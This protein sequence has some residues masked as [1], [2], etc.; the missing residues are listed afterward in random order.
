MLTQ[1]TTNS[2]DALVT[3]VMILV[4]NLLFGLAKH[5]C[6]LFVNRSSMDWISLHIMV[7]ECVIRPT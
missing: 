1:E 3:L 6:P 5:C 7:W 4:P 2:V